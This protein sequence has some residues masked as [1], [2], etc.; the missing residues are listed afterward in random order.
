MKAILHNERLKTIHRRHPWV[1]SRAI[2]NFTG[3]PQSGDIVTLLSEDGEFLARGMW[4]AKSEIRLRILT[5]EDEPIDRDFWERR[6]RQAITA[7]GTVPPGEGRRLINAENDYLPGLIVDQYGEWVVLQALAYGIDS[8]KQ[9]LA[10]IIA[11]IVQ[12]RGIYERSDVEV[13]RKEGLR[14]QTGVLWGDDLPDFV[15]ITEHGNKFLVELKGGHKTGFYLDQRLN[16]KT[17]ADWIT[18]GARVLNAFAYTGG[19]SVYAYKAGAGEVISVDTS[20]PALE[21][22]ERNLESNGFTD[23]PVIAA[24][25]FELLHDYAD[26]GEQF[27]AIVL[28]PP[29][30]AKSQGHVESALRGYKDLNLLGWRLLKPGGLLMTYSCSGLVET[31]LFRKVVFGALE[32]T[33]REAQVLMQLAAPPDHPVALTFPEGAYLKGL[34]C[35]VY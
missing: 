1:F 5:W 35:R 6:I 4:S 25:V 27:D 23:T 17:L 21:L 24:D 9:E 33:N 31:E 12:P 19:F 28:D 14:E 16:R 7:R 29:K 20:I 34:L 26:Q 11:G 30:F 13:R 32:D 3:N 10:E 18:P 22:A 15:E 8:R 2:R